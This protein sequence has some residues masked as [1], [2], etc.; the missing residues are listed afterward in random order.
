MPAKPTAIIV[1]VWHDVVCPWCR[2]GLANL[3]RAIVASGRPVEL[4]LRPY[5]LDPDAPAE[6]RDLR[7]WL[8]QKYGADRI[9]AMFVR[10]TAVGAAAGVKFQFDAVRRGPATLPAHA[11]LLAVPAA[12]REAYLEAMHA[13]YFERGADI[14]DAKVLGELAA[15][16]GW[17]AAAAVAAASDAR[18]QAEARASAASAGRSG[19]QGVPHVVIAGRPLHG[20][21]PTEAFA[22][23]LRV[24]PSL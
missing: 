23:A 19:I 5:L 18:L 14:G 15:S 16:V 3:Q 4:R 13:A 17:S 6:G 9:E 1:E 10:V 8:G 2:I 22:E 12:Q 21:Q 7:Q 20:A 11:T 24:A